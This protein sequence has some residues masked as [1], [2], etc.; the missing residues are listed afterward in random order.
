[1][2]WQQHFTDHFF[3][4][5]EGKMENLHRISN[6]TVR[7][8]YLKDLFLQWRGAIAAYDEGLVKGDSVLAAAVWRN[9]FKGAED[10]DPV[11]LACVV[12][13]VRREV[14]R[15]SRLPE[16]VLQTGAVGFGSPGEERST[17]LMETR[18]MKE[19]FAEMS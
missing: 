19:P 12:S 7:K 9:V 13:Y 11:G 14:A 2:V 3:T 17:V 1:M 8:S 16:H 5:A 10:V 6:G 15:V 18:G 4:L